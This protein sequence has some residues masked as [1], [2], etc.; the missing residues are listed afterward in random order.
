VSLNHRFSASLAAITAK[1][2]HDTSAVKLPMT[3]IR[4]AMDS[5][6]EG[7]GFEP[8]VPRE[9]RAHLRCLQKELMLR[10]ASAPETATSG[11]GLKYYVL[12]RVVLREC[13]GRRSQ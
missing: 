7:G 4:F 1:C 12:K 3:L 8:S 9:E 2:E 6:L 10:M 5:P 13:E 11:S